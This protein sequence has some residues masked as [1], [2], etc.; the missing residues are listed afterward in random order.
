MFVIDKDFWRFILIYADLAEV[1]S[2]G[3]AHPT[4]MHGSKRIDEKAFFDVSLQYF[5]Y[6]EFIGQV[7]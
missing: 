1:Q 3:Q 7:N 5:H 6:F 2:V 4:Q